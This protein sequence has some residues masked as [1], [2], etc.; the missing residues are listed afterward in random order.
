MACQ[1]KDWRKHKGEC[2]LYEIVETKGMGKG[3]IAKRSLE[4]GEILL[5]EKPLILV[6]TPNTPKERLVLK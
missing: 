2:R 6:K 4:P 3:L 5:R 1:R